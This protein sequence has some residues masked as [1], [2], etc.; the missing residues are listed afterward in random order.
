M[1]DGR[2]RMVLLSLGVIAALVV[3]TMGTLLWLGLV[4]RGASLGLDGLGEIRHAD[5][6]G[7]GANT[8]LHREPDPA[9]VRRELEVLRGSGIG[10]I[11]Q[12][13]QWA[14]IEPLGPGRHLGSHG[15]DTW[16]K[17]DRIV[18]AATALDLQILAR[19]DRP[20]AWA[21]PG[22]DPAANP[23]VQTP[24]ADLDQF[25][26]FAGELARRYQGRV[27]TF[28]IWN[29]PNL[30]GEWGGRPPDPA[31]YLEMLET[32][33][34]AIRSANPD[35]V[36]VLAGLAP[37]I[38]TGPDNLSD[39]LFLRRL[40]ELG[41]KGTF[42]VA[43]S[44]SYG[45]FTGPR[46][47]LID[48]A[49]TNFPR[50]V[51]LREVMLAF[52]DAQTPIWASEYGWMSLP[53]D[54]DGEPGI[55][56]NHSIEDQA[57]WTVDGIRRAREQWPWMPNITIWA[58]RWP[59]DSN[60]RDPTPFFRLMDKDFTPRPNLV[61]LRRAF[62]TAP[63][64]GVGLHQEAHPAFTFESAWPRVPSADASL[65]L[66]RQTG[67]VGATVR[68]RF[69]GTE[70][71][72]LSRRGP[73]MGRLRV[74]IDGQDTLPDLL[75]RNQGG[76]AVLDLYAPDTEILSRIPIASRLP[77]GRHLVELTVMP[78][79]HEASQG[80]LVII[81][82][83]LVGAGRPLAPYLALAA[84]WLAGMGAVFWL[85]APGLRRLT[86]FLG[87]PWTWLDRE[88]GSGL[89]LGELLAGTLAALFVLLPGGGPSSV[90]TLL[91]IVLV[92]GALLLALA[93]PLQVVVIAVATIPFIGVVARTGVFDRP[94]AEML[95][96][97]L[98]T[99]WVVRALW[100]RAPQLPRGLWL[101]LP[102]YF[103]LAALAAAVFADFQ[104]FALRDLRTVI[105]EPLLLFMVI[106][107]AA[108]SRRD[109]QRV[110]AALVLG[111]AL[112]A[113]VALILIPAGAV[114][115]DT[116]VPRLR[117]LFGSPNNLAMVLERALP[118]ALGLGLAAWPGGRQRRVWWI[119][120]GVVTTGLVLTFSR[121]AW[122]GALVGLAVVAWPAWTRTSLQARLASLG[123]A[124]LV[125]VLGILTFGLD[126]LGQAFRVAD[127]G[128]ESRTLLWDAAW[129][130]IGDHLVFGVGPDN[131]I[132]HYRAYLRPE[133]WREPNLSHP[134]NLLLD[135]WLSVGLFGLIAFAAILALFWWDWWRVARHSR[136]RERFIVYGLAG[137]M[138][139][140]LAHG[141][142]DNAYFLPELAGLFWVMAAAA[143]ALRRSPP[144][145]S[146]VPQL[147]APDIER[148]TEEAPALPDGDA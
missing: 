41:A 26:R 92:L 104:K 102:L 94:V 44:M 34:S 148:G 18:E 8:F 112:T 114:V 129:R 21:T 100:T 67:V 106:A 13:F 139:A 9:K 142:V 24:P 42:D 14:E 40:Y 90:W 37:T 69:D 134:H 49:R 80:G 52:G 6:S 12:E 99:A 68:F 59:E 55:W 25:A 51:L 103:G 23:R 5:G 60:A 62:A 119:A 117:G 71:G 35:A 32:V 28:Q 111:V 140:G 63:L 3:V 81:D 98:A 128:G 20:P 56:G 39:I 132:H 115:T 47:V 145:P 96:L 43:S 125:I 64:A 2:V 38:E 84:M 61:A 123:S 7:I 95:I 141:L 50:A 109:V 74:R 11:R 133:A 79:R 137:A 29:E 15:E 105:L 73:A 76:E 65:G 146:A 135:A 113:V 130:M 120:L 72:L 97:V 110:L 85:A 31:A 30:H 107:A 70:L 124:A 17:Y 116:A 143:Y 122:I 136:G 88:L 53:S 66:Q 91:R 77:A 4:Q 33:G 10:L 36:I 78:E 101:W 147:P 16:A 58:S 126:T 27:R 93:R 108:R 118:L 138:L 75:P 54:W 82:G 86:N 87:S 83:M 22:F 19:L 89:R 121:G 131:F 127:R 144:A 45:L 46:D 57:A 48:K 1:A